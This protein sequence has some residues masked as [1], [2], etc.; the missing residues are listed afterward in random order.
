MVCRAGDRLRDACGPGHFHAFLF[1]PRQQ[2]DLDAQGRQPFQGVLIVLLRQDLGGGHQRRLRPAFDRLQHRKKRHDRFAAADIPVQQPIHRRGRAH[3]RADLVQTTLLR[4]SQF[5][6]QRRCQLSRQLATRFMHLPA[7]RHRAAPPMHH[8]QLIG[9]KF[10]QRQIAPCLLQGLHFRRKMQGPQGPTRAPARE[11]TPRRRRRQ[12]VH[13]QRVGQ[14]TQGR[15]HRRA[16]RFLGDPTTQPIHRRDPPRVKAGGF[17]IALLE[18]LVFRMI[19]RQPPL[20]LLDSTMD[21][22][23]HA[24]H[25]GAAHERHVPPAQGQQITQHRAARRLHLGL[26]RAPP[27]PAEKLGA[28]LGHH[29]VMADWHR[30]GLET[31]IR[32]LAPVLMPKRQPLQDLLRRGHA[33]LLQ[34]PHPSGFKSGQLVERRRDHVGHSAMYHE[35]G[36]RGMADLTKCRPFAFVAGSPTLLPTPPK[37][38]NRPVSALAVG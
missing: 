19:D 34:L 35:E 38:K 14:M 15:P 3:V 37:K 7:R 2:R 17:V 12:Q 24:L 13:R 8:P 28:G 27:A 1:A 36:E 32:L 20:V 4:L 18:D 5:K 11:L 16:H 21:K 33:L 10:F 29:H 9:E 31:A 30:P 23:L 26:E 22:K 6:R 25:N